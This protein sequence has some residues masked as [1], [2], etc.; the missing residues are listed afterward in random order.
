MCPVCIMTQPHFLTPAEAVLWVR[1]LWVGSL[2][3]YILTSKRPRF[4]SLSTASWLCAL[5]P[6]WTSFLIKQNEG[7]NIYLEGWR[8]R[9]KGFSMGR[10]FSIKDYDDVAPRRQNVG[11]WALLSNVLRFWANG[12]CKGPSVY[13]NLH[14]PKSECQSPSWHLSLCEPVREMPPQTVG[15]I[16]SADHHPGTGA[17]HK[18]SG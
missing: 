6:L 9:A 13:K 10:G 17:W 18:A 3:G 15:A 2:V 16:C 14:H 11:M 12:F 1:M 7:N 4:T 8:E 5:E